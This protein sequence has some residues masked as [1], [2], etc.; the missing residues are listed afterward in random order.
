MGLDVVHLQCHIG[1]D[2]IGLARRGARVVGVDFSTEAIAVARQLSMRCGLDV[3][4]VDAN[5]FDAVAAL[6]ERT[7]DVV[8]TGVGA[9]GWLPDLTAWAQVVRDLLKPG[10]MLYLVELHP[11]WVAL[12]GDGS[13]ICQDALG[14][15]FTRWDK[16]DRVSYAHP[17]KRLSAVSSFE[18]LHAIS[19]VLTAVLDAGLTIELF[20]EFDVTPAPTPWLKPE[21][22]AST[23]SLKA[24][25]ASPSPTRCEHGAQ[26]HEPP[27]RR[28]T[29]A[30]APRMVGDPGHCRRTTMRSG[31]YGLV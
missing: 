30:D 3:E 14:A 24:R 8:Y 31:Q 1:T 27:S 6:G 11:M 18:R 4:W 19:E 2:T 15:R 5:V 29:G 21:G 12:I 13:T 23:G 25:H 7:F 10:G 22:T 9:I 26:H 28:A 20:H 17:E 16:P